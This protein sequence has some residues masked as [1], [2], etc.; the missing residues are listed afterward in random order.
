VSETLDWARAL[1]LLN[2]T[3]LDPELVRATLGLVVK[4]AADEALVGPRVE[5]LLV[6]P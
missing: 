5:S 2:A 4:H 6:S 1:A 3:A